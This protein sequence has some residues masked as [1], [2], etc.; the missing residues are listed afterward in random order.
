M[1]TVPVRFCVLAFFVA[2]ASIAP[3]PPCG[4]E[5][6]TPLRFAQAGSGG[7]DLAD[8]A[9]AR[10]RAGDFEGAIALLEGPAAEHPNDFRVNVVYSLA[11]LRKCADQKA[12]GDP[13]YRKL[14]HTPY[15]IGGRLAQINRTRPEPYHIVG[16]ALVI[17]ERPYKGLRWLKKALYY[18]G[19]NA[20]YWALFGDA[21]VDY[22]EAEKHRAARGHSATSTNV[23]RFYREAESA[24]QKALGFAGE[25]RKLKAEVNA[26]LS[27]LP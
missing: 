26:R 4:A 24:Y 1:Q 9:E 11:L 8:R 25:D 5:A 14:V 20:T 6:G 3:V 10:L 2:C 18:D 27:A 22:A 13:A 15:R 7:A 12:K 19:D 23:R 21:C 17:N 16:W